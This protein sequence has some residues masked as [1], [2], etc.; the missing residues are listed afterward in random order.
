[1]TTLADHIATAR[2]MAEAFRNVS[3]NFREAVNLMVSEKKPVT[4]ML[5]G[6]LNA[7][8]ARRR[9]AAIEALIEK[10]E[11]GNG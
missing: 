10:V 4:P 6:L 5:I 9:A 3:N 7:E 8:D 2:E 11:S 1:M